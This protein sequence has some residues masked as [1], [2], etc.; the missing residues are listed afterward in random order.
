MPTILLLLLLLLLPLLLHSTTTT[1]T[2]TTILPLK[3]VLRVSVYWTF[4]TREHP[5]FKPDW[6]VCFT[7]T[8]AILGRPG[9]LLNTHGP[10]TYPGG[11]FDLNNSL[12][13]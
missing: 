4:R 7:W 1:I 6:R 9:S 10:Y 12:A 3:P 13:T 8:R 2:V 5:V 11:I